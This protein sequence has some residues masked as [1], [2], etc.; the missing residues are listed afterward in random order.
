MI[1]GLLTSASKS[2]VTNTAKSAVKKT[3]AGGMK[4]FAKGMTGQTSADYKARVEG[5]DESGE[6][7]SPEERKARF[8]GFTLGTKKQKDAPT[9]ARLALPA[10][11]DSD[12][13]GSKGA[14]GKLTDHLV[15]VKE[16]LEKLLVLENNAIGRLHDRI[17]G[18]AR[19]IDKDAAEAEESKQERGK[20]RTKKKKDGPLMKGVKKKAGG[21]FDFLMTF[22]KAFVGF[23]LLEWLGD[24]ANQQKVTDFVAFFQGVVKFIG[25]VGKAIGEGF[26]WT[27][28]KLKEGVQLIKD[29][30][31]K[32]GEFFGFEWFDGEAFKEQLDT[33]TKVFTEGIPKLFDDLKNWLLVDLPDMINGIG[34]SIGNFFEPVTSFFTETIPN[35]LDELT[36]TVGNLFDPVTTFFTE[37][38]PNLFNEITENVFGRIKKLFGLVGDDE[39]SDEDLYGSRATAEKGGLLRGP[40]HSGGGVPIEAEGGE[41]VLNRNATA[42]IEKTMPGFLDAVNF[43]RFP[44]SGASKSIRPKFNSGGFVSPTFNAGDIVRNTSNSFSST[45]NTPITVAPKFEMGGEVPSIIPKFEMGGEVPVQSNRIVRGTNSNSIK[46]DIAQNISNNINLQELGAD[47]VIINDQGTHFTAGAE[48]TAFDSSSLGDNLP[49]FHQCVYGV[50]L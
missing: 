2:G 30:V 11:S 21:I 7:L 22:G 34:E 35:M 44:A 19:E 4:K 9:A 38:I 37:T 43:G 36:E 41:Y 15:K 26:T 48:E 5:K 33:I 18:T 10:G 50:R 46:L 23:K 6:Y 16:Y 29:T 1:K 3:A 40:R 42:G 12:T 24:P 47:K 8:K 17:L 49:P 45:T 31:T 13:G 25:D 28:D 27:I 20:V 14:T 32:L 39:E